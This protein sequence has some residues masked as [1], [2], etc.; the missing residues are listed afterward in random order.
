MIEIEA[1]YM[2][3]I[4]DLIRVE[5]EVLNEDNNTTLENNL[6]F[7]Q[8]ILLYLLFGTQRIILP[9]FPSN[10]NDKVFLNYLLLY[11]NF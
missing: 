7:L 8:L 5:I 9:S 2:L 3:G 10:S 6:P 11:D 4:S 1:I